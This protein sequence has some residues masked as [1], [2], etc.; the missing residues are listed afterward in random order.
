MIY[1]FQIDDLSAIQ[2]P[3]LSN[4]TI[5][6]SIS[7]LN[8]ILFTTDITFLSGVGNELNSSYRLSF[9][10]FLF[11][12]RIVIEN[13]CFQH[14]R[15]YVIDGLPNLESVIIG[16]NC[17]R[18]GYGESDDGICRITNCPNLRHLEIGDES[19]VDFKSFEISNLSSLQSIKFGH[20][21]FL[22]AD[23][24]LKGE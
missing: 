24:S 4:N 23:F 3:L 18:I 10:R 22:Y 16:S 13:E 2:W 6:N 8:S 9:T 1:R 5:I 21:C 17:F 11:L 20:N 12:K 19:F 14:V 7:Q 15:E